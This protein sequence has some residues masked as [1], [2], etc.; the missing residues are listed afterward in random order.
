MID[1]PINSSLINSSVR[2]S[3]GLAEGQRANLDR[4]DGAGTRTGDLQIVHQ[5]RT[6]LLSLATIAICDVI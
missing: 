3:G 2:V 5:V 6:I 1:P 4:R